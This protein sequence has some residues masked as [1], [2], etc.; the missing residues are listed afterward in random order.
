MSSPE[1]LEYAVK[2]ALFADYFIEKNASYLYNAVLPR[3]LWIK[4]SLVLAGLKLLYKIQDHNYSKALNTYV[5][6]FR[7]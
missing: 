6:W 1:T 3:K 4:K 7:Y 2:A 5:Q